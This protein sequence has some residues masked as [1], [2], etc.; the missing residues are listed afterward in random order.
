MLSSVTRG[1][2]RSV[3]IAVGFGDEPSTC[4]FMASMSVPLPEVR[5]TTVRS[6]SVAGGCVAAHVPEWAIWAS[7]VSLVDYASL[8]SLS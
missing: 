4:R 7:S 2:A 8:T 6:G 5:A 1:G 3:P